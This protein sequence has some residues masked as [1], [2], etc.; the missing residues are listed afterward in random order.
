[1]LS[2][3]GALDGGGVDEFLLKPHVGF[4]ELLVNLWRAGLIPAI[5][6]WECSW[7]NAPARYF[8]AVSTALW[9]IY[10]FCA[11]HLCGSFSAVSSRAKG[12]K[13]AAGCSLQT[14]H[15]WHP[16]S[17]QAP[18]AATPSQNVLRARP[19]TGLGLLELEWEKTELCGETSNPT[20]VLCQGRAVS[21]L[22]KRLWHVQKCVCAEP[23][24]GPAVWG[25]QAG[26]GGTL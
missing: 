19:G 2:S 6:K 5:N 22:W 26:P 7:Q 25:M 21:L 24:P 3:L 10:S 15:P 1:M 14:L 20:C 4:L 8:D 17:L 13:G 12:P 23:H 16:P 9:S 18:V 11:L